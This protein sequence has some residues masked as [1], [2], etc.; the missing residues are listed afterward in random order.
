MMQPIAINIF[1]ITSGLAVSSE[2]VMRLSAHFIK[3][4]GPCLKLDSSQ[5]ADVMHRTAPG[6]VCTDYRSLCVCARVPVNVV[7]QHHLLFI[8]Q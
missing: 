5:R 6:P 8:S 7:A 3:D 1:S 2:F 4:D